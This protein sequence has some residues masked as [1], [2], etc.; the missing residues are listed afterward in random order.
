MFKMTLVKKTEIHKSGIALAA[1]M[2]SL[3]MPAMAC[4]IY[5]PMLNQVCKSTEIHAS[6]PE[7]TGYFLDARY[8]EFWQHVRILAVKEIINRELLFRVDSPSTRAEGLKMLIKSLDVAKPGWR[9]SSNSQ[10]CNFVDVKASD[11][12][13][14]FVKDAVSHGLISCQ[15]NFRPNDTITRQEFAKI[16][17]QALVLLDPR[18]AETPVRESFSDASEFDVSLLPFAQKLRANGILSGY[19]NG[20]FKP[21]ENISR[22]QIAKIIANSFFPLESGM[23]ISL[24]NPALPANYFSQP[25]RINMT[26]P[27]TT[28]D[29]LVATAQTST[30]QLDFKQ[31][32]NFSPDVAYAAALMSAAAYEDDAKLKQ[33]LEKFGFELIFSPSGTL[34][35]V[36]DGFR[37]FLA[38]RSAPNADPNKSVQ[39]QYILAIRGTDNLSNV[40][41]DIYTIPT[42][43]EFRYEFEYYYSDNISGTLH[44]GFCELAYHVWIHI[45]GKEVEKKI[46]E[47]DD[48]NH[49]LTIV[50][51]SLGGAAAAIVHAIMSD[52]SAYKGN[53]LRS[54]NKIQTYTIG[55]PVSGW[56]DFVSRYS[57]QRIFRVR[58]EQD[59][60]PTVGA[61][62]GT[63]IGEQHGFAHTF[64]LTNLSFGGSTSINV[65]AGD[66]VFEADYSYVDPQ[67]NFPNREVV[68]SGLS[69]HGSLGY[70]DVLRSFLPTE[71]AKVLRKNQKMVFPQ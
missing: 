19:P 39:T 56:S 49:S 34:P 71:V 43:C 45:N 54:W 8:T 62:Y 14:D 28:F 33:F 13:K 24:G 35:I 20:K 17:Y 27:S 37:F 58:R 26:T 21:L 64:H 18:K 29:Q 40:L 68:G 15:T 63:H 41:T 31:Y 7:L 69:E 70:T 61:I 60:V 16:A 65:A 1:L 52:V 2:T 23:E 4:N 9:S 10:A 59:W 30:P 25:N 66:K 32:E 42:K 38:R 53:R 57:D 55:A 51:H 48:N 47:F 46:T 3:F 22:G 67:T 12:F 44:S 50:G 5:S 6:Q 36:K 11:W